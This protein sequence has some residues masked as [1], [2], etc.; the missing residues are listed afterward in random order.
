VT[1]FLLV[2][3][4]FLLL[5]F[6]SAALWLAARALRRLMLGRVGE[7]GKFLLLAALV[8]FYALTVLLTAMGGAPWTPLFAPLMTL[9][10]RTVVA[11]VAGLL[12]V[13]LVARELATPM[14]HWFGFILDSPLRRLFMPADAVLHR[15][16]FGPGMRVVEVGCG[17]GHLTV[18]VARRIEPKGALFSVDIQ[19]EMVEKTRRRVERAG[20]DNVQAFVAPAEKLPFD[21]YDADLVFVVLVLGEIPNR[22]A[23]LREAE[24]VLRPGGVLS[25]SESLFDPHYRF[26]N[27]VVRLAR[28]AGFE[29]VSTEGS[30]FNYTA[31]FRKPVSKEPLGYVP[32]L[33]QTT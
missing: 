32:R 19:P 25:I 27:D 30:L 18:E 24:R 7:L 3:R 5:L 23:A 4:P 31:T 2:L 6:V 21:I 29:H 26:R 16:A 22:L 17:T 1:G 9:S 13:W 11:I 15:M 28:H 33:G 10:P 8:A 14:P 12:A 20:L